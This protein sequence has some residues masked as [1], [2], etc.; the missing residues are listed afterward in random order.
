MGFSDLSD[1][2]A[3]CRVSTTRQA[4]D[5]RSLESYLAR[6]RAIGFPDEDI[7][8][9]VDSGVNPDRRGYQLILALIR[10]GQKQRVFVPE[11]SRFSRE[12]GSFEEVIADFE[13]AG[14]TIQPL[15]GRAIAFESPDDR[16]F[17]RTQIVNAAYE[18]DKIIYRSRMGHKFLRAEGRPIRAHFGLRAERG[19]LYHNLLPYGDSGLTY[20][21]AAI[22]MIEKFIDCGNLT[23][24]I[25]WINQ[26]YPRVEEGDVP[27]HYQNF[28]RWLLSGQLRGNTEYFGGMCYYRAKSKLQ[29][30]NLPDSER[31]V[32]E[33]A[34]AKREVK[35]NTHEPL[36]TPGQDR[37]IQQWLEIITK[38]HKNPQILKNPLA[39]LIV[40]G[41]C[42]GNCRGRLDRNLNKSRVYCQNAYQKSIDGDRLCSQTKSH[43]HTLDSVETFLIDRICDHSRAIAGLVPLDNPPPECP[44][45]VALREEIQKIERL[46]DPDFLPVIQIKRDKLRAMESQLPDPIA[47]D[48]VRREIALRGQDPDFWNLATFEEKLILYRA[49]VSR[50]VVNGDR[51][52]VEFR[53]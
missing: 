15:D 17:A 5:S 43:G 31:K 36:I 33:S 37:Q 22:A 21:E 29:R 50:I 27:R 25:D 2:I 46:N 32:L 30:R 13:R 20:A 8:W 3:Y 48:A 16:H 6:F 39:G 40:C 10:S 53:L 18:R 52:S 7:Y 23:K 42:G 9:D 47:G 35:L 34:I 19:R 41:E 49:I 38:T 44:E 11:F 24:T 28:K 4:R 45:I 26:R 51:L 12:P 1:A 14:A